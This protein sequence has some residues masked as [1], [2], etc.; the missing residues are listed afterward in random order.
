MLEYRC[1]QVQITWPK[2]RS[3][4]SYRYIKAWSALDFLKKNEEKNEKTLHETEFAI[5]TNGI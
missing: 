1:T 5:Y 2:T 4:L 3:V